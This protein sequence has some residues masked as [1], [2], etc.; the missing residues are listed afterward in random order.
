L[1]LVIDPQGTINC[2]YDEAIDLHVLGQPTITRASHVEPD[3]EGRWW[4]DL[5]PV[6][7]SRLGPFGKRTEALAAER[8][9]LERW[10][11][12][13][14]PDLPPAILGWTDCHFYWHE[15]C[16]EVDEDDVEIRAIFDR[17]EV[18]DDARCDTCN[19]LITGEEAVDDQGR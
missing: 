8:A 7:G 1:I 17:R 14:G 16:I 9:W 11:V 5:A 4:A 19:R 3:A 13:G 15:C 12:D 18:P 10:L 6:R 2:L